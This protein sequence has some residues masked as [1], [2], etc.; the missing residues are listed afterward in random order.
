MWER[1]L[2]RCEKALESDHPDTLLVVQNLGA[3]YYGRGLV[4]E[5]EKM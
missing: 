1:A 2:V 4:E 3:L 5:A